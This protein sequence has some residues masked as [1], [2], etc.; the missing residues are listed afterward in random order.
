MKP[1]EPCEAPRGKRL[2][3]TDAVLARVPI[4][5]TTLWRRVKAGTFPPPIRLGPHMNAWLEEV[6]DDKIAALAAEVRE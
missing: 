6:I 4:S 3:R 2:I 5:R 1:V